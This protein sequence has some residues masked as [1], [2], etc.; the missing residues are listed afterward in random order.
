MDLKFQ[1]LNEFEKGNDPK[2]ALSLGSAQYNKIKGMQSLF[3]FLH[4]AHHN[5]I[6]E[7]WG[8]TY[9]KEHLEDKLDILISEKNYMSAGVLA[10]FIS[11]LSEEQRKK[12]FAY[13]AETHTE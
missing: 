9:L 4:N 2:D 3:L 5:F 11:Y 8:G 10:T 7:V 12:L 6:E 1:S 13:I